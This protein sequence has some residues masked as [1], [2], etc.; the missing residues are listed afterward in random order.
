MTLGSTMS[1]TST[2][3]RTSPIRRGVWVMERILGEHFKQPENVP[4]LEAPQKKAESQRLHL[5][6]NE[7]LKLHSSHEGCASCHR[8]ID[9]IGFGLEVFDQLGI[10]RTVIVRNHVGEQLKW[11]PER[12]P[13][14]YADQSWPL[15]KPLVAGAETRFV[16]QYTKGRHRLDIKNVRLESSGTKLIDSH[17]GFTGKAKRDNA[18]LF[19]VPED[20]PATGWRLTAEVRGNGGTDSNGIITV[21]GPENQHPEDSLPNGKSFGTPSELKRLLL[22]DYHAQIIDNGVR[23]VLAYALGREIEPID[24]PAI[25]KIKQSIEDRDYRITALIEAVVLS[26]PFRHM[27]SN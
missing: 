23:R 24:R 8:Y 3:N 26:Y 15:T 9:P 19:A 16:F 7:M 1:V 18:W 5:S 25:K 14:S 6:H 21:S 11:T 12:T 10:S 2:P 27:E 13:K 4:D 20:A 17:F 22:T